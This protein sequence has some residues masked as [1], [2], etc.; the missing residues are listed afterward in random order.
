MTIKTIQDHEELVRRALYINWVYGYNK[1]LLRDC[2]GNAREFI[3]YDEYQK[4][5]LR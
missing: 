4:R 1:M 2:A 5:Y 3:G